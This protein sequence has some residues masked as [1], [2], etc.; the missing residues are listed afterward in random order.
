[1]KMPRSHIFPRPNETSEDWEHTDLRTQ[2]P[3][4]KW[5]WCWSTCSEDTS[6]SLFT[7]CPSYV[8][9]GSQTSKSVTSGGDTAS[10]LLLGRERVTESSRHLPLHL[11]SGFLQMNWNASQKTELQK[12][13][14][15]ALDITEVH[16]WIPT[17]LV[18]IWTM[19]KLSAAVSFSHSD[20][21][22]CLYFH[23]P[24]II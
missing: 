4:W 16:K 19:Q 23:H 9:R 12:F 20:K 5:S 21:T 22:F 24:L 10:L 2:I 6:N 3:S 1:M 15:E 7:V 11:Y 14:K 13:K 18:M 8:I 17:D